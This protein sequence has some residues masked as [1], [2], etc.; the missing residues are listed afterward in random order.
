[1]GSED[2]DDII[3]A[4]ENALSGS[5]GKMPVRTAIAVIMGSAVSADG[6]PGEA[7]RRRVGAALQLH[8]EF[9]TLL[10]IPTGG[11]FPDRPFSEADAMKEL[12]IKAGIDSQHII[13][14]RQS[15]T[16]LHNCINTAAIIKNMPAPDA[17]IVCSDNYHIARSRIL[18]RLTGIST[19]SR[20][21]P[22]GRQ[23][24]GWIR[25]TYYWC[26]EAIALP[27]HVIMLLIL[28]A[29]RKAS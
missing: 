17:V 5:V 26:R 18:L 23:T 16:T 15:K 8:D 19:I 25:W 11:I 14:E 21:M 4:I 28:K 20:P 3:A 6:T 7:M 10:F 2:A 13:I 22:S 24:A 9:S 27:I 12:L 1:V 29:F